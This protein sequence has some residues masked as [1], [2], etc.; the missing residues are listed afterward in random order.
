MFQALTFNSVFT[1]KLDCAL[2]LYPQNKSSLFIRKMLVRGITKGA[3][4]TCPRCQ[5]LG[6]G[7]FG[8]KKR[9]KI[10]KNVPRID[11]FLLHNQKF[12]RLRCAISFNF[13]RFQYHKSRERKIWACTMRYLTKLRL[14]CWNF[15]V[16]TTSA[17]QSIYS[18]ERKWNPN[19]NNITKQ[20]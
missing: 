17:R 19:N 15:C 12:S 2:F 14:W 18:F 4:G 8:E 13:S 20:N 16:S 1:W 9:K 11:F 5:I 3:R 6:G 7:K 10:A